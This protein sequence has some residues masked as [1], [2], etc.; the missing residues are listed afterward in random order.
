MVDYKKDAIYNLRLF[1][2]S[3]LLDLQIFNDTDYYSDSLGHT[4]VPIL[5]VQQSPDFNQYLSGKKH[6]IYDKVGM[7]YDDNWLICNEQVLFTI[8]ATDYSEIGEIRNAMIDIFRRMDVTAREVNSDNSLP[9]GFK[10][11]SI[12]VADISPTEPSKEMAGF[13]SADVILEVKYSRITDG[14]GRFV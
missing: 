1:L 5:P 4:F 12:Y 11:H 6:I 10:F 14:S 9:T 2:W 13:L 8:F 7:S 3:N